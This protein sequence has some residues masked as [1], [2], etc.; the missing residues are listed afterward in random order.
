MTPI[1]PSWAAR[2]DPGLRRTQNEDCHVA[3]PDQGL[4]VV[5][6][7]VGG[8]AGGEIASRIAVEAI[9]SAVEATA[10]LRPADRWPGAFDPALS[11][12]AS[13]LRAGFDLA[14]RRITER[15]S[16]SLAL[17]GMATT[18]V[19]VLV[20]G[21]TAA[22]AHAGDS[23]GYLFRP[24]GLTRLTRDH[25]WVEE[26]V[27]AGVLTAAAAREHPWRNIV[28]RVL[29]AEEGG[30]PEISELTL[31]RGDR[32]LL[33]TDGLSSVLPEAEIRRVLADHGDLQAA[34]DT[35]VRLVTARGAPDNV[36]VIVIHID[37]D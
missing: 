13:R 22:I 33:C 29:S 19:A 28:T 21:L 6:D 35:L 30:V 36:T 10:S 32:L 16:A 23:R 1:R 8:H 18:A 2:T 12:G 20:D 26:Q 27:R 17:Q 15:A 31:R 14:N 24:T 9:A 4:F 5:A 11:R 34:C 3:R 7:G 25:S 37:A